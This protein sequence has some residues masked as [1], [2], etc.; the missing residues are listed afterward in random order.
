MAADK[1]FLAGME[2]YLK[3][4]S[5]EEHRKDQRE[6]AKETPEKIEDALAKLCNRVNGVDAT[7]L[8]VWVW[9]LKVRSLT[10]PHV[11]DS[12]GAIKEL[13][14]WSERDDVKLPHEVAEIVEKMNRI[15]KG[16]RATE[17]PLQSTKAQVE[18]LSTTTPTLWTPTADT[19][20][21]PKP[22]PTSGRTPCQGGYVDMND[23]GLLIDVEAWMGNKAFTDQV[24]QEWT[25]LINEFA[26][27]SRGVTL[28]HQALKDHARSLIA[29]SR[30][31]SNFAPIREGF[32]T[33]LRELCK[34]PDDNRENYRFVASPKYA[35]LPKSVKDLLGAQKKIGGKRGRE[36]SE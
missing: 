28:N 11:E 21:N 1:D 34:I 17:T 23:V 3:V 35:M 22:S 20:G 19:L 24:A 27:T 16:R 5:E 13:Q 31:S 25:A 29:F 6:K 30:I 32:L 4:A 14:K 9:G 33:I 10:L 36:S 7:P 15:S 12:A 26:R 8:T 2:S 18:A